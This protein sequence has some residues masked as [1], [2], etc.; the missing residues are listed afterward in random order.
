[1]SRNPK[2]VNKSKRNS[3][4]D[5]PSGGT[6]YKYVKHQ[7]LLLKTHPAFNER[8]IQEKIAEDPSIL[9]IG[10]LILKDQERNQLGAGRLDLLF[11]DPDRRRIKRQGD[12]QIRIC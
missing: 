9:G 8:W 3:T 10:E 2:Y 11:Q 5:H 7:K 12:A 1:M 4:S 6:I